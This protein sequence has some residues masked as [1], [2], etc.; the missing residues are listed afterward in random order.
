MRPAASCCHI[1]KCAI[2]SFIHCRRSWRQSLS[3]FWLTYADALQQVSTSVSTI[4]LSPLQLQ[5]Q[6]SRTYFLPSFW[7][8]NIPRCQGS[9]TWHRMNFKW[10][11]LISHRLRGHVMSDFVPTKIPNCGQ[12]GL[13]NRRMSE[14]WAPIKQQTQELILNTLLSFQLLYVRDASICVAT[15]SCIKDEKSDLSMQLHAQKQSAALF[16]VGEF[17]KV[18]CRW[19]SLRQF[20]LTFAD[21]L[22]WDRKH[23]AHQQ[24]SDS[25]VW[26]MPTHFILKSKNICGT[27]A[28][29]AVCNNIPA[30]LSFCTK[31]RMCTVKGQ[32]RSDSLLLSPYH[33][34]KLFR[35]VVA[36]VAVPMRFAVIC[37][38][39]LEAFVSQIHVFPLGS[40]MTIH[41]LGLSRISFWKSYRE[42]VR[43]EKVQVSHHH[44]FSNWTISWF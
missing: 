39:V 8:R 13:I 25:S 30:F 42:A 20:C 22:W 21:A 33:W 38:I 14:K 40:W 28:P 31:A 37:W 6:T 15:H 32:S 41:V 1:G 7:H 17:K 12:S 26:L 11:T 4:D 10:K 34:A 29:S 36:I 43:L 27:R 5:L 18:K 3:Q 16:T 35:G 19:Q 24:V 44:N 23:Y 9:I 2:S